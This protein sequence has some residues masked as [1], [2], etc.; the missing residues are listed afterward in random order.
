MRRR[1]RAG[2]SIRPCALVLLLAA[3]SCSE[4]ADDRAR[5]AALRVRTQ[6]S[7]RESE[8]VQRA[9]TPQD[10]HRILYHAPTDL[11]DTSA[12]LTNAPIAGI[13]KTSQPMKPTG[14][15]DSPPARPPR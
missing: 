3:S 9:T 7:T 8:T 12:R 11:S 6:A 4:S 13:E 1:R 14:H 5:H 10:A 15:S 2:Y